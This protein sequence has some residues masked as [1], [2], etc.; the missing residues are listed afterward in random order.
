MVS[1]IHVASWLFHVL[2]LQLFDNCRADGTDAFCLLEGQDRDSTLN[3]APTLFRFCPSG[4]QTPKIK[5][6]TVCT[7]TGAFAEEAIEFADF[8]FSSSTRNA[9]P[10]PSKQV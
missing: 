3:L 6:N 5:W 10:F 1:R 7:H 9:I 2:I 4:Q 8:A